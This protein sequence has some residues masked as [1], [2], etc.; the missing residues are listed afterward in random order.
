MAQIGATKITQKEFVTGKFGR[1]VPLSVEAL[2]ESDHFTLVFPN[3]DRYNFDFNNLRRAI[4]EEQ[5]LSNHRAAAR[6]AEKV[7]A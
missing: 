2:S 1:H 6:Q 3:G 5:A 4:K 7:G